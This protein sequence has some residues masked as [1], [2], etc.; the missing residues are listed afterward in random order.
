MNSESKAD[1][2]N[3][4]CSNIDCDCINTIVLYNIKQIDY[5]ISNVL[6]TT[7]NN[8]EVMVDISAPIQS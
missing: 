8:L 7:I 5:R 1:R 3:N 2:R 6:T 4:L